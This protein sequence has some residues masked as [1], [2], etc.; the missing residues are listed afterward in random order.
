MAWIG[1]AI[2]RRRAIRA[3]MRI[4]SVIAAL[5]V[6]A[7]SLDQVRGA[8]VAATPPARPSSMPSATPWVDMDYGPFM[9]MTLEAPKPEGNFAYKGIV[10]PLKPDRSAAMVF[11]TDLL[12]WAAGWRGAFV[13]WH[14]VLYDGSHTTH[15][16]VAGEQ[17]FGTVKAPGWAKPGA[18]AFADPRELPFGP[19]PRDWAQWKGLYRH[20]D[21]VV[22]SYRVGDADVLESAEL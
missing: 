8:P 15:C 4:A 5:L 21:H 7:A 19:M 13:D 16:R 22:L 11:D 6:V 10:V 3:F 2:P 12:R 1:F 20:G 17:V 9:S 14:N 18:D